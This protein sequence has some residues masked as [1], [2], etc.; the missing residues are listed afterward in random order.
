MSS[1]SCIIFLHA[2]DGNLVCSP[3]TVNLINTTI[4]SLF[5][6][7]DEMQVRSNWCIYPW[8][9]DMSEERER[10]GVKEI[11]LTK[12]GDQRWPDIWDVWIDSLERVHV[13]FWMRR[14]LVYLILWNNFTKHHH[15]WCAFRRL[16]KIMTDVL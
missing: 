16:D 9:S 1:P 8:G 4:F 3:V 14:N 12:L 6:L 11:R 7:N 15:L 13:K 10:D 2:N 5:F